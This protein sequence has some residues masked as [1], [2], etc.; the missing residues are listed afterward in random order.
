LYR[1]DKFQ[2]DEVRG[3]LLRDGEPVALT[4]KTFELLLSLIR[5]RHETTL[6]EVL[7]QEVWPGTFVEESNLTQHIS[8]LRKALG[9]APQDRRYIVTVPGR[10]YRLIAEVEETSQQST[11]MEVD[12]PATALKEGAP[13]QVVMAEPVEADLS[14]TGHIPWFR[15]RFSVVLAGIIAAAFLLT[16]MGIE[17]VRLHS[18]ARV[19]TGKESVLLADFENTTGEPVFDGALNEGLAVTL[20]QSPFLELASRERVRDTLRFMGRSPDERVRISFAR[21]VCERLGTEA[22]IAGSIGRIGKA[23]VISIDALACNDGSEL[24]REQFQAENRERVL[25]ELGKAGRRLR[26]RLGESLASIQKFDVPIQQATTPSLEALRAYSLGIDQRAHGAEKNSIPFFEHAIE[27]DPD[28]AMAHAQLG[29]A[30]RNLG[31]SER[32]SEYYRRAYAIPRQLSEREKLYL[33]VRYYETVEGDIEKAIETNE[34]W[35]RIYPRDPRPYNSLAAW[36][37]VIGQYEKAADAARSAIHLEPDYYTPYANLATSDLALNRFK[38]AREAADQADKVRR[39]SLY[40][41]RVRFDL[42]F[43][44][45]DQ[46][47]M[48]RELEWGSAAERHNDMLATQGRALV[49]TG[50]LSAGRASLEQSWRHSLANGLNDNAAYSIAQQALAEADFGNFQR[51]RQLAETALKTG[52]GID[53]EETA[54][55]ALAFSG[56]VRGSEKLI[57]ELQKRFPHHRPLNRACLPSTMAALEIHHANPGR[58]IAIL[59]QAAP[60]DLSEF[61]DLSPVYVRGIAYLRA[62][63][64]T[65]AAA[66]FQTIIEHP[67]IDPLSPRHLL[68]YL[69][70]GR[71]FALASSKSQARESYDHFLKDCSN[72]DRDVPILKEARREFEALR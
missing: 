63:R 9:E 65:E 38:E 48:Q 7:L 64:G 3:V 69:W 21:E 59:E 41:H 37:Q 4:A 50:R 13:T 47:A 40:T 67:G 55:E 52:H 58:A 39:D 30:Y 42:A 57:A 1:F 32:A 18:R 14:A 11:S 54:A 24:G 70:L 56:D 20:G 45:H 49:A 19:L 72:A 36:Y 66:Q 62:G 22:L 60:Y 31:E 46:S 26:N 6:K 27:L 51:A 29:G 28:F 35:T 17:Y 34:I 12:Q 61:S 10:G 53:A 16:G 68:A 15:R 2:A 25:P 23:Y 44:A 33:S 71:A 5:H 43:I 8:M